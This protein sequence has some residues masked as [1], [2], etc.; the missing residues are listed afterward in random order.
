MCPGGRQPGRSD[1]EPATRADALVIEFDIHRALAAQVEGV[2]AS[3]LAAGAHRLFALEGMGQHV[4][5]RCLRVRR[6]I[7]SK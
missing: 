2:S 7:L 3:T 5:K 6:S 1:A 4:R